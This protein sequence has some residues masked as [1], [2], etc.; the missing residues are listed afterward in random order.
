MHAYSSY[1]QLP[2]KDVAI[3]V[4]A[5]DGTVIAMRLTDRSGR[6][7]PISVPTPARSESQAPDS[8]A[9]PYTIVNMTAQ[10]RGYELLRNE[11][12]QVFPD[13][14]TDQN[15]EMIPLT[16]LPDAWSKEETF[17]TPRQNL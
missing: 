8:A 3:T 9:T 7:E 6:I 4:T 17:Q 14:T 13:T 11:G 2:L 5:Q 1:A 12:L 15:L 10:I 16:E